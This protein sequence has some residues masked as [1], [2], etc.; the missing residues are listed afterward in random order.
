[1][2]YTTQAKDWLY[3]IFSFQESAYKAISISLVLMPI[4]CDI[5]F[6]F[7][8]TTR[9]NRPLSSKGRAI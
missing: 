1:M 6:R 8:K 7:H 3:V 4:A 2:I 9:T 5:W